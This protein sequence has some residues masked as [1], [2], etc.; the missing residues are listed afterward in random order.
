MKRLYRIALVAFIALMPYIAGAQT[1]R[2]SYFLENSLQRHKLNPA[3]A[4]RANYFSIPALGN[5]GLDVTSNVGLSNFVFPKNGELY[6][7]LNNNVSVEE[8]ENKLPKNPYLGLDVDTDLLNFGFYINKTDFITFDLT[9]RIDLKTNMPKDLFMFTK[10]GMATTSET[11][12]LGGFDIFSTAAVKASIGYSKDLN[13]YVK[14]LRVGAKLNFATGLNYIQMSIEEASIY[15]SAD[16]WEVKS[17]ANGHIASSFL[18]LQEIDSESVL[19]TDFS[20]LAPVGFGMGLDLG[21]EYV[22]NI[23]SIVDGMT[24]SAS[25]QNLGFFTFGKKNTQTLTSKGG[26][27]FEGFNGIT[28]TD[29]DIEDTMTDLTDDLMDVANYKLVASEGFSISPRPTLNLGVEMPFVNNLMS[30]G[31]LYT[32][33]GGYGKAWNE[34]TLSYNLTPAKWFNFGLNYSFL[35]TAKSMGWIIE[36]TPKAGVNFFLGSDYT[37]FAVTPQFVPINELC[38]NLRLGLSFMLG[39]KHAR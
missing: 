33:R 11:Y 12:D 24:F 39:S 35:N 4:P 19:E 18:K 37:F 14:G 1:L 22:L 15:A 13:E 8:F 32:V 26:T 28:I 25:V 21:A 2:G 27:T 36:F 20:N 30:V 29:F 31:A 38:A 6:T 17:Q 5:I 3:F 7:Y 16:K 23:G 10:R 34:L 9:T